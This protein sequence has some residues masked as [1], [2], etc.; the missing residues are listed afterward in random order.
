MDVYQKYQNTACAQKN[1]FA[2]MS[3]S[4]CMLAYLLGLLNTSISI[5]LERYLK[6]PAVRI[7]IPFLCPW[8]Q[9]DQVNVS[10]VAWINCKCIPVNAW[11]AGDKTQC[12]PHYQ[13]VLLIN[14]CKSPLIS[15]GVLLVFNWFWSLTGIADWNI[16]DS[17]NLVTCVARKETD[18]W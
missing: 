18:I 13:R 9:H 11:K 2:S 1:V 14:Y 7:R 17:N 15:W 8:L 4:H 16:I 12:L 5:N 10:L 6:T 3:L